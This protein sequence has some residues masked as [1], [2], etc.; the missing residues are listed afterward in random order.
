MKN[1]IDNSY[2]NR[3]RLLGWGSGPDADWRVM[4]L[5]FLVVIAVSA[6]AN[7]IMFK[8]VRGGYMA[9]DDAI[10]SPINTGL[11]RRI[12]KYYEDRKAGFESARTL[13][14]LTPDPSI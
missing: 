10:Q 4:F 3:G 11:L 6:I 14:E 12:A 9:E 1:T 13:P 7:Y 2:K 5:A 8:K